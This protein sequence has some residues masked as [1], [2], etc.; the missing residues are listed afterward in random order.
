M[1]RAEI[2]KIRKN[3]T[4]VL[5][6][7]SKSYSTLK[8]PKLKVIDDEM[9]G[10]VLCKKECAELELLA[11]FDPDLRKSLGPHTK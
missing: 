8:K 10:S 7:L 11:E 5:S 4:S 2:T 1:L 3:S 9:C 6:A